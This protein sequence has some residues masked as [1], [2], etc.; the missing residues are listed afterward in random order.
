M[1]Y[2]IVLLLAM[3]LYPHRKAFVPGGTY[4]LIA[5]MV[6]WLY[7]LH[8]AKMEVRFTFENGRFTFENGTMFIGCV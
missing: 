4:N 1:I 6:L 7:Y 2:R 8:E 3:S 5:V